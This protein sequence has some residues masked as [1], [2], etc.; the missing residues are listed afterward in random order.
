ML[1]RVCVHWLLVVVRGAG[2]GLG[3]AYARPGSWCCGAGG[4]HFPRHVLWLPSLR[5][6]EFEQRVALSFGEVF[7]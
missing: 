7:L 6:P 2:L 3:L 5:G 1:Q 4:C